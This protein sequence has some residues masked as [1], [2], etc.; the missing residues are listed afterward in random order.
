MQKKNTKKMLTFCNVFFCK[1]NLVRD[2]F[3]VITAIGLV[4]LFNINYHK[5]SYRPPNEISQLESGVITD[6]AA[7]IENVAENPTLD[8][9]NWKTYQTRWYGFELKY[10]E[11]WNKPLLKSATRAVKW[12]YRY[13]FRKSEAEENNPYIGFDVV[14]Y[15][16]SKIKEL[17][18]TDEFPTLKSEELKDQG[19]CQAIE[20]HLGENEEYPAEQ[21][22]ISL[23]DECYNSAFFYTLTRDNYIYNFIPVTADKQDQNLRVEKEIIDNFPEFVAA[24]STIRLI[25]IKRPKSI[26]TK[27]KIT[28]PHPAASTKKDALGRRVCDKK[29]DRPSNSNQ[30]K[31][32]HLDM[33]CCLDPDEYPNPHCYYPPDKY[34]KYLK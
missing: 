8:T 3:I 29:N 11:N 22:Y 6:L 14:V 4:A 24:A 21:I 34:R 27:P 23:N 20:G 18:N 25:D 1:D 30:K 9:T 7:Q 33:E 32:K 28:A 10:P 17:S 15:N 31:R 12:E 5:L 13:E 2:V 16:V 19:H 26:P